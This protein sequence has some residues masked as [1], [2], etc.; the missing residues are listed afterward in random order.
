M[1]WGMGSFT[2]GSAPTS[3]IGVVM[4]IGASIRREV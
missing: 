3:S 1:A 4:L 2:C